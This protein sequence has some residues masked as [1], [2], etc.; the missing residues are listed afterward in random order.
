MKRTIGWMTLPLLCAANLAL[1]QDAMPAAAA[2]PADTAEAPATVQAPAQMA[3]N[4][5]MRRQGRDMRRCLK[6]KTNAAIIRCA[7]PGR[8]P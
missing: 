5:P 8:K 7:E 3:P 6:L 1:A 4:K 2:A